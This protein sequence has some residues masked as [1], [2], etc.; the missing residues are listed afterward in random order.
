MM[1]KKIIYIALLLALS[2]GAGA[3]KIMRNTSILNYQRGDRTWLHFGFSLGVNYMDYKALLS[4]ANMYRAETGKL[5]MGFLVGIISEL[6]ISDDLGLRFLP[7]LEFATRSL[8]YTHVPEEE[9]NKQYAYNEAVYVSLPLMLKYKAKRV[10]NFRPFIAAGGSYKYDF[11][12]HNKID[13][14]KSV[15][16]RTNQGDFF[17]EIG[18]GSD[19][20][21]P[22]F[23]FGIELRFS[24][25]LTDVLIH[26]P[27]PANPG[28]DDYTNALKKLRARIFTVCFNFE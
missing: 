19:F 11:Q 5:E 26:Q 3:Q 4:G 23:K 20:Y 18:G 13:P 7:G 17:L 16:F 9:E 14:D 15:F 1:L 6:R 8:V 21:L 25:G 27:D 22:Y 10:N 24:L 2:F 12:K 28:Y